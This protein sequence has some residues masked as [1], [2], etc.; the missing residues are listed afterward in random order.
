MKGGCFQLLVD[1]VLEVRNSHESVRAI[2]Q[3]YGITVY[4]VYHIFRHFSLLTKYP[5]K[6]LL[7]Q[8]KACVWDGDKDIGSDGK[9]R[10]YSYDVVT[11]SFDLAKKRLMNRKTIDSS[12]KAAELVEGAIR[13]MMRRY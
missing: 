5:Y 12:L 3:D 2:A 9:K 6:E 13:E 7:Y 8:P 11:F 4:D 1:G 10:K